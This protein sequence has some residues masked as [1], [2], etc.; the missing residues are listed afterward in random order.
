MYSRIPPV[1][2]TAINGVTVDTT[3]PVVDIS[4]ATKVSLILTGANLFNRTVSMT[5]Q[6]SLDRSTFVD[7]NMLVNNL[8]KASTADIT[9]TKAISL[10]GSGSKIASF[11]VTWRAKAICKLAAILYSCAGFLLR[12]LKPSSSPYINGSKMFSIMP[13]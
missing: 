4:N 9:L 12:V 13:S 1:L 6:V 2:I 5:T 3:S 10:T 8:E 11:F 7:Y